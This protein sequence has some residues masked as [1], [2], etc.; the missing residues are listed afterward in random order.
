MGIGHHLGYKTFFLIEA[1]FVFE[2]SIAK[3][4]YSPADDTTFQKII[5]GI[6]IIRE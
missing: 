2:C 1:D 5:D 3:Y 6:E 4:H